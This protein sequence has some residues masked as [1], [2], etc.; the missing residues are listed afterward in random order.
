M[1]FAAVCRVTEGMDSHSY[2]PDE[3]IHTNDPNVNKNVD[4]L[5]PRKDNPAKTRKSNFKV[6]SHHES[7]TQY[8][9]CTFATV[10]CFIYMQ[11]NYAD[12]LSVY[13]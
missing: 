1:Y 3:N 7:L 10:F 12:F 9:P 5:R 2:I 11:L 4:Q 8:K 13:R 6:Q